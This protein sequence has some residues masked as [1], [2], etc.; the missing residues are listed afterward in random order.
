MQIMDH[1]TRNHSSSF[2]SCEGE[3]GMGRHSIPKNSA[4]A[5]FMAVRSSQRYSVFPK[6]IDCSC[7]FTQDNTISPS[8][9]NATPN[10]ITSPRSGIRQKVC[11]FTPTHK[12]IA[13]VSIP[14]RIPSDNSVRG[15]SAVNTDK[16]TSSMDVSAIMRRFCLSR[17][18]SQ[19][20]HRNQFP[21]LL[22]FF[23]LLPP[24][25]LKHWASP[26]SPQWQCEL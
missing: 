1:L 22:S 25:V 4:N 5:A 17:K 13:S 23:C 24:L 12:P 3:Y 16:S 8:F 9:A 11:P 15:S 20:K 19:T 18:P 14:S 6:H 21:Y 26:Q 7:P 10:L 2:L